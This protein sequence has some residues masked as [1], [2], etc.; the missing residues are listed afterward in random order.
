M[1]IVTPTGSVVASTGPRLA[2]RDVGEGEP[3]LLIM[4]VAGSLGL[5]SPLEPS[6]VE[7][8]R[9]ISFD[10]RGLGG[11]E[12]GRGEISVASMADDA[13]A[14]LDA[15]GIERAHVFGWSLGSAAC[16]ELALRHPERV[17]SLVLNGTWARRDG[18]Q[19][20]VLTGL[21]STWSTGDITAALTASG[22]LFSPQLLN[23]P[24]FQAI[25]K[26][27]IP[28]FPQT[29]EQV[30]VVGE[31]WQAA[32]AHDTLSRLPEIKAPTIVLSGEQDLLTSRR[33]C[34]E[35]ANA[36]AGAEI[37]CFDGPGSSHA[38]HFERTEEVTQ[39]VSE[40]LDRNP[41]R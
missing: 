11:S 34:E 3:L 31:Q 10:N 8:R 19:T 24:E 6:L 2:Y 22:I 16:Q 39:V 13:A 26:P 12:R 7:S 20:A 33:Q 29:L 28:L 14:V 36:I 38:L 41:L 15:L 1:A 37:A 25:F 32:F 35:V 9:I 40:F 17:G 23:A 30:R 4:G 27:F 5:W 21:R 18:F